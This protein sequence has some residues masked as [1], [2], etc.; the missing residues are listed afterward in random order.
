MRQARES[1]PLLRRHMW[2]ARGEALD[3]ELVEDGATPDDL[4]AAVVLPVE[5]V[6]QHDGL[7]HPGR[8]VT[9]VE[10]L[11]AVFHA[12]GD[13]VVRPVGL[14]GDGPRVGV[15]DQLVHVEPVAPLRRPGP[16]E[17]KTVE[18]PGA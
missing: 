4:G 6:V 17:A 9:A 7:G 10:H 8:R 12:M 1:P 13:Q 15:D 14:P 16:V 2:V 5:V 3:V 18:R 11:L